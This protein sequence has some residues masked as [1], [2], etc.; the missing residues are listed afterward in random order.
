[1][2]PVMCQGIKLVFETYLDYISVADSGLGR[3]LI[4]GHVFFGFKTVCTPC[5]PMPIAVWKL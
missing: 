3:L 5:N 1:M 4:G 2:S